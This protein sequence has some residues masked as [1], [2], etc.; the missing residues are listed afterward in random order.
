[1]G[2][3]LIEGLTKHGDISEAMPS[4]WICSLQLIPT[5]SHLP[6]GLSSSFVLPHKSLAKVTIMFLI[7]PRRQA[8][9]SCGRSDW[10]QSHGV[11]LYL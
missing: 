7:Y 4:V 10:E 5:P 2:F 3:P 1:M 8:E 11:L 9:G 6:L